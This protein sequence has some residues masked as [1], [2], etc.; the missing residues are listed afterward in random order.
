MSS[1]K[2][3]SS[4]QWEKELGTGRTFVVDPDTL[5]YFKIIGGASVGVCFVIFAYTIYNYGKTAANDRPR[6]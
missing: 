4:K 6:N 3:K 2:N 1:H 5:K